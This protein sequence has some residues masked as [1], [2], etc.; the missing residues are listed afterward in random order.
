MVTYCVEAWTL[1]RDLRCN[2]K[3][4]EMQRNRKSMKIPYTKHVTNETVMERVDQNR[5]LLARL[6]TLEN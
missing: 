5:T 2:I 4:F 3:A 6:K 1:N